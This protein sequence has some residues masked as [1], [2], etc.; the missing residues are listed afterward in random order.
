MT[1][2]F[3]QVKDIAEFLSY[4]A[5]VIG[6]PLALLQYR[7]TVRKEQEDREYGTYDALDEKYIEFLK[8]C[9]SHPYLDIFDVP[10]KAPVELSPS[11]R[12]QELMAFFILFSILERSYLMY[13]DQS[14]I[15]K[16]RQWTGWEDYIG[17]YLRRP[18]FRMA[19]ENYG[20]QFDSEFQN[21][22]AGRLKE[23]RTAAPTAPGRL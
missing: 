14:T 22:M 11:Q 19:W 6:V 15:I 8:L 7:M 18:N 4:V 17:G 3:H 1:I 20:A 2:H 12:K 23:T 10:D 9:L 13:S 21:Y 5:V 16:K